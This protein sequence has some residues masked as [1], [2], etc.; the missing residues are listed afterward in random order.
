MDIKEVHDNILFELNKE[1]WGYVSPA[2]IDDAL[3]RAQMEEFSFLLGSTRVNPMQNI[4]FGMTQKLN[5]ALNPFIESVNYNSAPYAGGYETGTTDGNI[6]NNYYLVLPSDWAYTLELVLRDGKAVSIVSQDKVSQ[7]VRSTI[8][9]GLFMTYAGKGGLFNGVAYDNEAYKFY[10]STGFVGEL[11]YLRMPN[12]P[13]FSYT[14]AGRE[15]FYDDSTSI[16][17]EWNDLH[18][19]RIVDRALILIGLNVENPAVIQ[20]GNIKNNR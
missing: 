17:L 16:D 20:Q 3:H 1:S 2:E 11:F 14:S 9:T 12:K 15:I 6:S 7:R 4:S 10:N 18:V 8:N 19:N 5:D 13:L